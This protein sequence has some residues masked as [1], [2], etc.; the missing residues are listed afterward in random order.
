MLARLFLPV[1]QAAGRERQ[2][3]AVHFGLSLSCHAASCITCRNHEPRARHRHREN[4]FD[5]SLGNK[6][7]GSLD[8][9]SSF[10]Y[11]LETRRAPFPPEQ[12]EKPPAT[13]LGFI[14]HYARPF[15]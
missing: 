1:Q 9:L 2:F 10:F 12:P 14:F 3:H 13:L 5:S 4:T 11:W 15:W 7:K 8:V 6:I